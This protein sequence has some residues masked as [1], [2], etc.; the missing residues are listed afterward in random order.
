MYLNLPEGRVLLAP[1]EQRDQVVQP[2]SVRNLGVH[3]QQGFPVCA[4]A[5][6]QNATARGRGWE[7]GGRGKAFTHRDDPCDHD[8]PLMNMITI[9]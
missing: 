4:R 9:L 8:G 7:A 5:H 3:A 1:Q 2:L 6:T